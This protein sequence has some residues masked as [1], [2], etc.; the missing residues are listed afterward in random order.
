MQHQLLKH[1][2]LTK[3]YQLNIKVYEHH[4]DP[5]NLQNEKKFLIYDKRI[6]YLPAAERIA[7]FRPGNDEWSGFSSIQEILEQIKWKPS[8]TYSFE[9]NQIRPDNSDVYQYQ[10]YEN[11]DP[12]EYLKDLIKKYL[13]YSCIEYEM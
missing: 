10:D 3:Q 11:Q 5:Q 6:S 8:K 4:K 12:K 9:I 7:W 2:Q 1:A 13:L